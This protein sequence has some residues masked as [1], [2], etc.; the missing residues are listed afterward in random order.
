MKS[1]A[2][3][4]SFI[5]DEVVWSSVS[6][7]DSKPLNQV[8]FHAVA[9]KMQKQHSPTLF[10]HNDANQHVAKMDLK[11]GCQHKLTMACRREGG[12]IHAIPVSHG[13]R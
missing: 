5:R 10:Y 11:H 3:I 1:D 2:A 6:V 12:D 7:T 8:F 13:E 9:L 4:D